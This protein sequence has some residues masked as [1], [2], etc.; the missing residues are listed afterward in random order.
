MSKAEIIKRVNAACNYWADTVGEDYCQYL[1]WEE[2]QE[3]DKSNK[4]SWFLFKKE[5]SACGY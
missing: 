5:L 3:E 4:E 1:S 2:I